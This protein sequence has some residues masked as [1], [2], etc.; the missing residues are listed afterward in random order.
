MAKLLQV[1]HSTAAQLNSRFGHMAVTLG[2]V[3]YESRGGRGFLKGSAARGADHPLFR[4]HH[5]IVL[6]DAQERAAR[7]ALDKCVGQPYVLGGV[8]LRD[9]GTDCSGAAALAICAALGMTIRRLFS[10]ATWLNVLGDLGFRKGLGGGRIDTLQGGPGVMDR[11]YPGFPVK[12]GST[13]A[14]H[15]KWIKARL[16]F[17]AR[18]KHPELDGAA[19]SG[20]ALFGPRTDKVVRGFQRRRALEVDGVVGRNTWKELNRIR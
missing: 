16:N 12:Q 13:K 7:K 17:A 14:G 3:N 8:P 6:T 9:R 15:V 5:H 1:G 4:Q 2:G 18:D 20:D 10:T 11:P 19:L